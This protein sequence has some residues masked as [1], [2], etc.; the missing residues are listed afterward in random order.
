MLFIHHSNSLYKLTEILLNELNEAHSSVLESE[1]IL[2]Q[3]PGMKR[4]L[5]QQISLS[6]GIAA[7][8]HFPLP[9]RFIWDVFLSQFDDIDTLSAYDGEVLR[10]R[11]MSTLQQHIDDQPLA[12]LKAY[13][14]QDI[15]G[16]SRFQ[17]AEKMADLFDQYLVY[18]P[19][20]IQSWEQGNPTR[21]STE[22]WQAYLWRLIRSQNNEA[23]RADLIF[24][25]V[26]HLSSGQADLSSLPDQIYVFAISAMSP[27]YLKVLEALS[28]HLNVHIFNLN[29]CEHY[30]G[31]I[32]SKKEQINQGVT[33]DSENELLAS[34]GKQGREY[35]DQ[36]YESTVELID[37]LEF[38][39][40][41][42]DTLLKRIKYNIL[43]LSVDQPQKTQ[44]ADDSIEVVSCYSELRELQVLQDYLLDVLSIDKT[45]Q[46]H[47]IVVM[48]PDI[49]ALAPF[50]EAVF[51]QQQS[52][53]KIPFSISDNNDLLSTPLLQAIMEWI[54]LPGS[55]LTAN[56][57]LSWLELPALQR[58]YGLDK[59]AIETIRYWISNNHIHWGLNKTHKQRFMA[60]DDET[61][62]ATGSVL[63]TWSHGINQLL[64]AYIMND[65]IELF[66][67]SVASD[68]IISQIY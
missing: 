8:L 27:L 61:D 50:I 48:C 65:D 39:I 16:L 53:T 19:E 28:Q 1:N 46:A 30:W 64:T 6:R 26:K 56:E 54:K 12:V 31:D 49:N 10:W 14:K 29:P 23:H 21:S 7:N 5:Q 63:N 38:E 58:R 3:N 11:L 42:P 47:D 40:I 55:R 13:L 4:W 25:L 52:N 9:S 18:R 45:L 33:P 20:M 37:N 66:E 44:S 24:K 68:S 15:K 60:A 36:F 41:E 17:L 22:E 2:V 67:N 34:L 32:Q 62:I 59:N 43:N 51:G 57:I 35:I